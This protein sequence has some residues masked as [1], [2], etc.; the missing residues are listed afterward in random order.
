M[1]AHFE[2]RFVCKFSSCNKI[3]TT[4]YRLNAHHLIHQGIK[5]FKCTYC[6]KTFSQNINLETHIRTHTLNKPFLCSYEYCESCF[7]THGQLKN[8]LMIHYNIK[9]YKC[10]LCDLCVNRKFTLIQ[11]M[12]RQHSIENFNTN[13][14]Q[15]SYMFT[16]KDGS[17]ISINIFNKAQ[18]AEKTI[19]MP[20]SL[21]AT[22]ISQNRHRESFEN[23]GDITEA[24]FNNNIATDNS[25]NNLVDSIAKEHM[26]SSFFSMPLQ[27]SLSFQI[28]S[29]ISNSI[30][31]DYGVEAEIP[32][33]IKENDKLKLLNE[34]N[35]S[36]S[37]NFQD[38]SLV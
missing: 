14:P 30:I 3:F 13:C 27:S 2:S 4:N 37:F 31:E 8:H 38:A 6:D 19:F 10:E 5:P 17:G 36:F 25:T 21:N 28:E 20:D 23:K 29:S 7:A 22:K 18:N 11:H 26:K 9:L 33:L 34:F 16:S 32:Q 12:K 35:Q 15:E 1:K 24:T